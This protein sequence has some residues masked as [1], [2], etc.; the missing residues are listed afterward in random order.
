MTML[1][2]ASTVLAAGVPTE[3]TLHPVPLIEITSEYYP[4]EKFILG[5]LEAE[6]HSIQKFYY[7]DNGKTITYYSWE[8]MNGEVPIIQTSYNGRVYDL[9]RV[10]L[11]K[12]LND[13]TFDITLSYLK[14]AL[15]G[16]R[17]INQLKLA[18][19]P[20]KSIYELFFGDIPEDLVKYAKAYINY[21]GGIAVGINNVIYSK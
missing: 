14:N 17:R 3:D 2:S 1:M 19:T 7:D 11:E 13:Q 12:N 20:S 6:D 21:I 8:Q 5:Y 9:V 15:T 10:T 18:Y 16:T 4:G